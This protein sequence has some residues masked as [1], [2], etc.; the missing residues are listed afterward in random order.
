MSYT[1]QRIAY[2]NTLVE[3][4]I[5]KLNVKICGSSSGL[6]DFGDGATHQCVEDIA[7]L[8]AIPNMTV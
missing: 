5:G 2:G 6:S 4:A 1:N 3:F 7:I 8:R